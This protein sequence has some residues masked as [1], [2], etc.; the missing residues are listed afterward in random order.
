MIIVHDCNGWISSEIKSVA[1]CLPLKEILEAAMQ[2]SFMR[3]KKVERERELDARKGEVL[4][5]QI[6]AD[7]KTLGENTSSNR[8]TA[9]LY[10]CL[11]KNI[12]SFFKKQLMLI[13]SR[14][15]ERTNDKIGYCE[16]HMDG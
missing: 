10:Y 16:F 13:N 5:V 8:D 4:I 12:D 15:F 3:M 11:H 2:R 6:G 7:N 9:R 1:V 14:Y